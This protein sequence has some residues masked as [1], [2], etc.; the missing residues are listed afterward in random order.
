MEFREENSF[1]NFN[2]KLFP[3]LLW[4]GSAHRICVLMAESSECGFESWLWP[5]WLC[6]WSRHFTIIASLHPGVNGYLRGQSWLLCL[7]SPIYAPKWQQLSCILPSELRWFQEWFMSLMSR[8]INV[9]RLDL[10]AR[11]CELYKNR[12]LLFK[13]TAPR[14]KPSSA[15]HIWLFFTL[16]FELICPLLPPGNR[17]QPHRLLLHQQSLPYRRP[18]LHGVWTRGPVLQ[19]SR[20]GRVR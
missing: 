1:L 4:S 13:L 8:S 16:S 20:G 19:P 2:C 14:T 6:P 11:I 9:Q 7:I 10:V 15:L 12:V 3:F 18:V 17:Q 5:W